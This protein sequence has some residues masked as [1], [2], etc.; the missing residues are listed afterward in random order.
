MY[1]FLLFLVWLAWFVTKN[2][3]RDRIAMS[4]LMLFVAVFIAAFRSKVGM[5]YLSYERIFNIVNRQD[6]YSD[7]EVGYRAL[8]RFVGW[9]GGS[10]QMMFAI[11]SITT[12]LIFY[13]SYKRLSSD[14]VLSLSI[15]ILLGQMYLNTFNAI[16]QC[17]AVAVFMFSI[18]YIINKEYLKYLLCV[19]IA[20][21][22]HTTALILVPFYWVLPI[23]WNFVTKLGI[24][25][26][27]AIVLPTIL[28]TLISKSDYAVYLFFEDYAKEVS[29]TNYMYLAIGVGILLFESKL[30]RNCGYRNILFNINYIS[31][32]LLVLYVVFSGTPITM[33]ITRLNYYFIFFYAIIIAFLVVDLKPLSFRILCEL[34][35]YFVLSLLFIRTTLIYGEKYHLLP[36][37]FNFKLFQ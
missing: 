30:L 5:D 14:L 13:E 37:S 27:V 23:R 8:C 4:W 1:F 12:I 26:L 11:M 15:F 35:I 6:S 2:D 21:L 31:V 20:S 33:V 18:R 7:I 32:I 24:L 25:A 3:K 36:Y 10:S 19:F 29:V 9:I 28:L 22:F 17:L 34:G 16:R